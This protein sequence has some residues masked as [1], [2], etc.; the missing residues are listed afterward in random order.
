[1]LESTGN[2]PLFLQL[3]KEL[4]IQ[5]EAKKVNEGKGDDENKIK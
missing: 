3:Q 5:E 2:C 4:S 1:M